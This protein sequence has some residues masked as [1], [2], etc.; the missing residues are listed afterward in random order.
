MTLSLRDRSDFE[1]LC[2]EDKVGDTLVVK[3][4]THVHMRKCIKNQY[5]YFL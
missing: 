4:W 3:G 1:M 5:F 2:I